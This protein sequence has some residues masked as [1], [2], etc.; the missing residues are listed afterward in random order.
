M[1]AIAGRGLEGDRYA[2]GTG[3]FSPSRNQYVRNLSLIGTDAIEHI[4]VA[5]DHAL[6]A[7]DLRRNLVV[8]GLD[9]RALVGAHL[10]IGEVVLHLT[11][12]CPACSHLDRLV[13]FDT[14]TLLRRRGGVR[15]AILEGGRLAVGASI[16]IEQPP[17]QLP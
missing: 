7:G 6:G 14:K 9:L 4:G 12:T 10:R 5:T 13:G 1:R 2:S 17:A 3:T 15:A 11:G 8:S 16:E